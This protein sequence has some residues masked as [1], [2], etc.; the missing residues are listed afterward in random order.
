MPHNFSKIKE[1][2]YNHVFKAMGR[3][4]SFSEALILASVNPQ[5][6]KRFFIAF[7]EKCKFRTCCVQKLYWIPKQKQ[8]FDLVQKIVLN[9]YFSPNEV[10][11]QWTIGHHIV[12]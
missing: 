4:Y 11:N 1:K 6:D 3:G 10:I 5:Y 2:L 12:G 7:P 9:L 8:K